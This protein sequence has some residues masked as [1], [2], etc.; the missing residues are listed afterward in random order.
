[1]ARR[2]VTARQQVAM[3]APWRTAG[4]RR[5][6]NQ[7]WQHIGGD[8]FPLDVISHYMDRKGE[9]FGD[10]KSPLYEMQGRPPLSRQIDQEGYQ[11]PVELCTDGQSGCVYDGHHRIDI[12]RQLG[13]THVPVQ[14]SWRNS[15]GYP[16]GAYSN[17]IEPWL[18][19]WLTDMRGGRETV[20]RRTAA[21]RPLPQH[22]I[23]INDDYQDYTGQILRGE[24]TIET[25]N[26][27]SLRPIIGHDVAIVR[28]Y[29]SRRPTGMLVG[30]AT[31]GEPKL[32]TNAADF[33]ADYHLHQ[34]DQ[35]SPHHISQSPTGMKFGYPLHNVEP[36]PEPFPIEGPGRPYRIWMKPRLAAAP[37]QWF[38]TSPY[39]LPVGTV[40]TPGG[41]K[42]HYDPYYKSMGEP[43]RKN[44][45]WVEHRPDLLKRWHDIDA[46]TNYHYRVEPVGGSPRP[47]KDGD[48]SQ[49]WV[50]P[51]ARIVE[52]LG[53][54]K[55]RR[56]GFLAGLSEAEGDQLRRT[57]EN[58]EPGSP[59]L[60]ESLRPHLMLPTEVAHH[61]RE[62]DR[63]YDDVL[64]RVIGD[65]GIRQPLRISTDGTHATLHEGNH[66]LEVARR[67][68]ISHVP[69][70]V[71]LEKPG[72]VINNGGR[73]PVPLEPHLGDWVRQN[74][75][76]LK[77]FWS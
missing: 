43:D 30:Y 44:H 2:I 29:K 53:P 28:N 68:G 15:S 67:M 6:F 49:G 42:S 10:E 13:H 66:R 69:V 76:A 27:N 7:D 20:G 17:K 24:K 51:Q 46:D 4:P 60:P 39:D 22:G 65:Q 31:V 73:P 64:G 25:R 48:Y 12:A 71:T 72:E 52:T 1:M 35:Y 45:V 47:Y 5:R 34:V 70:Q 19:K 61:Y 11:K 77:S 55:R 18:R 40:L 56:K 37:M 16:N 23:N 41:G 74:S 8:Y 58:R 63:P 54:A 62:Y 33:D 38:H 59:G 14:V 57:Y 32:Y 50:V 3:L 21:A 9:G 36:E 75:H 26:T